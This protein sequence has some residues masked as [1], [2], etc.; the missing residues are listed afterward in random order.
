MEFERTAIP[1]VVICKPKVFGDHRGY[2]MESFRADRLEA[3]LGY[4]VNFCQDN[5]SSSAYGVLRGLHYQLPPYPQSKL[6]RVLEGSVVDVAVDMRKGSPT[7]GKSV[8]VALSAENKQQLFIPRGFAHGFVVLS[9]T[10][11][12][13]YK[14]DNYYAP[15]VDSGVAFNDPELGIDWKL[16]AD[17]LLLSD[18]D[19][20]QP[21]FAEAT[22]FDYNQ[23][24]Y[25]L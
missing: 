22:Y 12:F 2:F 11:R 23:N 24:L 25:D 3:F 6:V 15:E 13:F 5:E 9:E 18:K 16:E 4:T 17:Q 10:A 1:D 21:A 19:T 14:C 7:F 8:A 20:K